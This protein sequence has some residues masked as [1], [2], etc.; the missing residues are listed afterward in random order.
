MDGVVRNLDVLNRT[1]HE[2]VEVGKEFNHVGRLWS[3]FYHEKPAE[4]EK[5]KEDA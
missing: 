2:S 3:N 5:P 4:Q 1:L